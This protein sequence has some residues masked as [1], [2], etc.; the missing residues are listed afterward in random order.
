MSNQNVQINFNSNRIYSNLNKAQKWLDATV[1]T[2][3]EEF[4]PM[5]Q[6]NLRNM[7]KATTI[8][9]SGEVIY[10]GTGVPYARYLYYGKVMVGKPPK[11]PINK[12]LVFDKTA[13]PNAQAKWF[14]ASKK[15]NLDY[16]INGVK[17]IVRRGY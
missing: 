3:T 16:W 12:N 7:S 5:R 10:G 6:G 13:H 8:Y 15:K 9:G 11:H 2:D 17:K 4:L 1:L 14:E